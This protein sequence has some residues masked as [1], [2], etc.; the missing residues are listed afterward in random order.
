MA[1]LTLKDV[2]TV[3]GIKITRVCEDF[4]IPVPMY[5]TTGTPIV[6]DDDVN[7]IAFRIQNGP[8]KEV[9]K[10]GCQV[11]AM[12]EIAKL[13]IE[14]LN[15]QFPCKENACAI[16]KLEEAL[17]WLEKRTKDRIKRKV[18]GMSKA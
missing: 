8:V 17:M 18:E 14:G 13:I 15:S 4:G 11:D 9:G 16:T 6:I 1:L 10:N 3:N 12:I 7:V 5:L 2:K